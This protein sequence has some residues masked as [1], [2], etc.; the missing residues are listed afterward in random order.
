MHYRN[1]YNY[2]KCFPSELIKILDGHVFNT[3][4]AVLMV[5][6]VLK[7]DV[8]TL[9]GISDHIAVDFKRIDIGGD[10]SVLAD[11]SYYYETSI[12]WVI[13]TKNKI[14][15]LDNVGIGFNIN[16]G[17]AISAGTVVRYYNQ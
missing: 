15:C 11:N 9:W 3:S 2:T 16:Y 17:S 7:F 12:A 14:P 10:M 13:G 1:Q 6:P 4:V 8:P 5:K